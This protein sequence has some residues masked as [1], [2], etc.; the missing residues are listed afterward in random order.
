[1]IDDVDARLLVLLQENSQRTHVELAR[2]VGL[3]PAAVHKRLK[4]LREDG[5]IERFTVLLDRHALGLNL[6]CFIELRFKH[7]MSPVNRES[8]IATLSGFPEV[9]ECF[10][11]TGD[12]D[13]IMK[14]VV[15]D[16]EHLK[17]FVQGLAEA[18]D[19]IERIRTALALEEY[20]STTALPVA[21]RG[22]A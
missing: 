19:V 1:L 17:V 13:A 20:K 21:Q 16:Q 22:S 10:T 3:S 18:Q 14:V 11:L 5:P 4:R 6:L 12:N 9:L 2:D 8:L 7:N 15:R